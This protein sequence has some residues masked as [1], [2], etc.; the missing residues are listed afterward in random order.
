M[1][2]L[3]TGGLV[4]TAGDAYLADVYVD[5]ETIAAVGAPLDVAADRVV[6][7]TGRYVLPGMIDPH[8]HLE[9]PAAG[10]VT[11]DDFTSGTIAAAFGGTTTVIHF[12]VPGPGQDFLETLSDWRER[13]TIRQPVVDVGFHMFVTGLGQDRTLEELAQLPKLGV[14]TYKVFTAYKGDLM[15]DDAALFETLQLAA[16]TNAL[17]MV[18][19]ENGDAIDVLVRQALAEGKTEPRWHGRTRPPL[20][21][22]EATHRVIQ[23]ARI[24]GASLYVVHV[25]CEESLVH[26]ERARRAGWDVEA[27]TC[28]HY[29]FVDE[30]ALDRPGFEPAGYVYTPPPRAARNHDVLWRALQTD[31]LSIVSSDHN[32]FTMEQKAIGRDDFS[33]IPNGAPG[34]EHRLLLLHH[35]GVRAGRISLNRMVELLATNPAKTFGLHPRKGT[36]SIGSDADIVIF[37]PERRVTISASTQHSNADYCMY[38]GMEVVGAPERVFLRGSPVIDRGELVAAPGS[39]EFIARASRGQP[40]A[41]KAAA[42]A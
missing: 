34:I 14:P 40:L 11:C 6:D 23:L 22:A 29:L 25:S 13:L 32:A 3:I 4:V 39:G 20:T 12:C 36:L 8:V 7:A 15:L 19:A 37:D 35:F 28:T 33:K 24:A 31:A 10:T 18:H 30:D 9:T 1:K 41:P 5:G 2:T 26:V 38:E 42:P 21:E 16:R 17:V 27:E